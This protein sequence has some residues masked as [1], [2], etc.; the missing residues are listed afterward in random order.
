MHLGVEAAQIAKMVRSIAA[1]LTLW[2]HTAPQDASIMPT[3]WRYCPNCYALADSNSVLK[4]CPRCPCVANNHL[5]VLPLDPEAAQ[6]AM[7]IGGQPALIQM[8]LSLVGGE[9]AIEALNRHHTDCTFARGEGFCDMYC[10]QGGPP[11]EDPE[12]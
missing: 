9:P 10:E 2:D 4:R 12:L 5:R 6:A 7:R 1:V 8:I 3:V 11:I